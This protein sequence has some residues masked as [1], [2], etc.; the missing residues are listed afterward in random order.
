MTTT[1]LVVLLVSVMGATVGLVGVFVVHYRTRG[2]GRY[3]EVRGRVEIDL[4]RRSLEEEIAKINQRL[5]SEGARWQDIN[6]LLLS[7]QRSSSESIT[8]KASA[9]WPDFLLRMGVSPGELGVKRNQVFILTPF[10]PAY[11][12]VFETIVR[13]TRALG[14]NAIRGDEVNITGDILPHILQEIAKSRIV[15][16]NVDGRNPNVFYELGLAHAMGK[17]VILVATAPKANP[18]DLQSQQTVFYEDLSQ[19]EERL[20]LAISKSLVAEREL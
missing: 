1:E 9:P 7:A 8:S 19:L 15:V 3:D 6:H 12:Q 18:F 11:D 10:G 5:T 20:K 17:N 13:A 14:L 2:V 16:A 4:L